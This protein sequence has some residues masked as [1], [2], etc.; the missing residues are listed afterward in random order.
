MERYQWTL[1]D[2]EG[3]PVN[4]GTLAVFDSATQLPATIYPANSTLETPVTPLGS[5][6][7]TAGSDGL[8]QFAAPKGNYDF[9]F[10]CG[11]L[12][13]WWLRWNSFLDATSESANTIWGGI[14]GT[15]SNQTDLQTALDLK[16]DSSWNLGQ[17]AATSSAQL[18]GV[19]SDETGTGVLV[20]SNTPTLVTPVLGAATA[21][22]I[23]KVGIT[24]PATSATLTIADGKTL[25]VSNNATVSG[26]NTG[27]QTITLTGDV[28][29]SG[30]GTF[31][32]TI[33]NSA[34]S[35]AKMADIAT[36]HF[37]GRNT[38]GT[39][40]PESLDVTTSK[41]M[42]NLSGT[43][44][45][46]QTITLTGDVTG[47]G[48]TTFAT[49][50]ANDSV[51][52]AKMQNVTTARLLGRA[53]AGSGDMEEITLGTNLSYTGTT[54]NA[55]GGS[56]TPGGADTQV[57][58][59]NAGA[60]AGNAAFTFN[61][62][63]GTVSATTF[64]G[65]GT[66]LT[67]TAASLTAGTATNAVN[68]G[69][70]DDTTTNATM[71]LGWFTASTGNL[72]TKVSSTKLTFNPS[73]GTLSATTFSGA[74]TSLTGTAASLT[75]GTATN[76]V[77]SGITDDTST[78]ATMY[79]VWVTAAT[80]NL[81]LKVSSTDITWNPSTNTLA[82]TGGP[83]TNTQA[84]AAASTDGLVLAT[85]A[86]ATSGNQ[87]WSP[88]LKFSASGWDTDS[89][90]RTV[91]SDAWAELIPYQGASSSG[92][93]TKI[94]WKAQTQFL[95]ATTGFEMDFGAGFRVF[96]TTLIKSDG[97]SFTDTN[98]L[99]NIGSTYLGWGATANWRF[100]QIAANPPVAQ[101]LSV[102]DASGTDIAGATWTFRASRA[103]GAGTPGT[104]VFQTSTVAAS[105]STLQ[106]ATTRFTISHL[107]IT[108]T[109]PI[110]FPAYTVATLPAGVAYARA[111]VTDA[112]GPVWGAAVVGGGAVVVPVYYT[113]AAWNVG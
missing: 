79:P 110:V 28:T 33:A 60:F 105:S 51:T 76:A 29:G 55:A 94:A 91:S 10:T 71:Y 21:T 89:G 106:T 16:A 26:T 31:A 107:S 59:N 42:L 50:I 40:V 12:G 61:A 85:S 27:D 90:G 109:L 101:T 14:T 103:T 32:A 69:I 17:F 4:G 52:Y 63:T 112:L 83:F 5:H 45:G 13:S 44:T 92:R 22:S 96:T 2:S 6:V 75:A 25:T 9:Y 3:R 70:T 20:Y 56:S 41:T 58:Y 108:S 87:K 77:N 62:G 30:T 24:A 37:I 81:P 46:D 82:L 35:L 65:A 23:N 7:V 97:I 74:G 95:G 38:A 43:N 18:A 80:G 1:K 84:V 72:P 57:Q 64:S 34:V 8:V 99:I 19:I 53:T 93:L 73:T 67:G 11:D 48:T 39:G 113:G 78:N 66:S 47:T 49:T 68:V 102:Q 15:L 98:S 88:R 36:L 100:G 111:F 54:L 86:T 104:I